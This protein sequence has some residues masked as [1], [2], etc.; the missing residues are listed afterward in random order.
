[1]TKKHKHNSKNSGKN[2]NSK[3]SEATQVE[4]M[5]PSGTSNGTSSD[6]PPAGT[7]SVTP[8]SKVA[9]P[10]KRASLKGTP[11]EAELAIKYNEYEEKAELKNT[12][13]DIWK[14]A[15][16]AGEKKI[17]VKTTKEVGKQAVE[18][19]ADR[20]EIRENNA[21][22]QEK[23]LAAAQTRIVAKDTKE[24]KVLPN[25]VEVASEKIAEKEAVAEVKRRQSVP[26]QEAAKLA[27]EKLERGNSIG[28]IDVSESK[29]RDPEKTY[30]WVEFMDK[31]KQEL[32]IG[33]AI[34]G[35][36]GIAVALARKRS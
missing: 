7:E 15:G 12:S 35:A 14:G 5:S 19:A 30:T 23:A 24:N 34:A 1:M 13:K 2:A 6:T 27:A 32:M 3:D 11:V 22:V 36:I 16:M 8:D 25:M 10:S 26:R 31:Y 28:S 21:T 29:Y 17:V 33:S 4:G 20:F 18:L 9:N